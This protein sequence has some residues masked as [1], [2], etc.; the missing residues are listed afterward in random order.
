MNK[1]DNIIIDSSD[2]RTL[3]RKYFDKRY[4][5]KINKPD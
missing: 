4:V 3:T 2:I 1:R 5:C